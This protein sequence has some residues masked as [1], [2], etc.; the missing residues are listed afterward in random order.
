MKVLLSPPPPCGGPAD[1][2]CAG[3]GLVPSLQARG[4]PRSAHRAGQS[5]AQHVLALSEFQ[6]SQHIGIYLHAPSLREVDTTQL[7]SSAL[8]A[9]ACCEA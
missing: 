5:I 7:I 2:V 3:V 6:Q 1:S 9:G 4:E 8:A